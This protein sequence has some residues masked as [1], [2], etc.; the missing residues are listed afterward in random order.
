MLGDT[1]SNKTKHSPHSYRA[2]NPVPSREKDLC[3]GPE[4]EKHG[5]VQRTERSHLGQSVMG[6]R[7]SWREAG[8]P[9]RA[10]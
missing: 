2:Y 9:S 6:K 4:E 7:E 8:P 3:K 10:S 1:E 5:C